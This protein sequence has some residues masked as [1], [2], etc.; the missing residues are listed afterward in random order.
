MFRVR[1]LCRDVSLSLSLSIYIFIS[2]LF[3]C[4]YIYICMCIYICVCVYRVINYQ[5]S[6]TRV[7]MAKHMENME[8]ETEADLFGLLGYQKKSPLAF[9]KQVPGPPCLMFNH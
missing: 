3:I 4:M 1:G 6:G 2:V 5:A 8:H 7:R 9:Y